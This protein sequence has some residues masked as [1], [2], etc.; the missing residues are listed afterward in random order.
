[1]STYNQQVRSCATA[2]FPEL[3]QLPSCR[4]HNC[5]RLDKSHLVRGMQVRSSW[6]ESYGPA[7]GHQPGCRACPCR[8]EGPCKDDQH[9]R[10]NCAGTLTQSHDLT[11]ILLFKSGCDACWRVH[12]HRQLHFECVLSCSTHVIQ[13]SACFMASYDA[14][15]PMFSDLQADQRLQQLTESSRL[16]YVTSS[17]ILHPDVGRHS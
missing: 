15:V 7:A 8:P 5:N 9:N 1:M 14:K 16:L 3:L 2:T 6:H 4:H 17:E 12:Q 11:Q 10:R 13:M